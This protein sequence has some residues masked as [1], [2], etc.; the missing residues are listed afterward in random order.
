MKGTGSKG[1]KEPPGGALSRLTQ[2]ALIAALYLALT[3]ATSFMS[4]SL[5][6]LRLAEALASLPALFPSAIPGLFLGCLLANLM[7]PQPLGLVDILA[8]SLVTFLAAFLTWRLAAP[9]RR[10]LA[11]QVEAGTTSP[12]MGL[13]RLLPALLAPILL[14]ALIVGSY[15]PFLLQSGRPS[16]AVVAA[17]MGSIFISQSLV[18][19]GLGLPLVLALR[20]TPWA[21]REYLSQGG[22]E[23]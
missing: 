5:I 9:W 3:L 10:S 13:V 23:S 22:A 15:L 20:W 16:L 12:P 2:S 14:N 11:Q 4:F 8:G 19:M 21:K 18:I 6:Q 7:N 17:S 1:K